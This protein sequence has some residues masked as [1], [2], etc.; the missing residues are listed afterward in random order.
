MNEIEKFYAKREWLKSLIGGHRVFSL[1]VDKMLLEICEWGE[2]DSL[3]RCFGKG[4]RFLTAMRSAGA[5]ARLKK[6]HKR[7]KQENVGAWKEISGIYGALRKP[8]LEY[9]YSLDT[10]TMLKHLFPKNVR[11]RR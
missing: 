6:L 1:R 8:K 2:I 11:K 10:G 5:V 9:D 4:S 3:E 7:L